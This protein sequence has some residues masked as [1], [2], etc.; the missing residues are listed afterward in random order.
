MSKKLVFGQLSED[1]FELF[2]DNNDN[3][4]NAVKL[5]EFWPMQAQLWFARADAEFIA[6]NAHVIAALPVEVAARISDEILL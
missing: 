6:K 2:C 3:M 4:A 1:V 5:T